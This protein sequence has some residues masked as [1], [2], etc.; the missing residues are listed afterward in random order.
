MAA[1]IIRGIPLRASDYF[2]IK[3]E[4]FFHAVYNLRAFIAK[5]RDRARSEIEFRFDDFSSAVII[6]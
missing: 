5:E 6:T 1:L 4:D 2:Q 3:S